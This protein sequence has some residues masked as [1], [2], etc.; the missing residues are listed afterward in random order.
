VVDTREAIT[1][2]EAAAVDV[3]VAVE[4]EGRG[5]EVVAVAREALY[6]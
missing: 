2:I 5:G 6:N 4:E 1:E 3:V